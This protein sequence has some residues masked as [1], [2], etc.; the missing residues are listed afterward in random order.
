[1]KFRNNTVGAVL[2]ALPLALAGCGGGSSGGG[3][4]GGG[5]GGGGGDAP[6]P[7]AWMVTASADQH[8]TIMPPVRRVKDGDTATFSLVPGTGYA[9]QRVT[10]CNGKLE[11][12][13]YT[14]RPV[15]ANCAIK[16]A[17]APGYSVGGTVSGL[18]WGLG[19]ELGDRGRGSVTASANGAFTLPDAVAT[20]AGYEVVVVTQPQG[21]HCEVGNGNGTIADAAVTHVTVTCRDAVRPLYPQNGAGW[22]D[23]VVNDGVDVWTAT[24]LACSGEEASGPSGCLHGGERRQLAVSGVASC[25]GL[26]ATDELDAFDWRCDESAGYVRFLAG[27]LKPQRPL[28]DLLDF[29]VAGWK[30]NQVTVRDGGTV[31]AQSA[32]TVWWS[33]PVRQDNDG[34]SATQA[35]AAGTVVLVSQNTAAVYELGADR[36]ALVVRPGAVLSAPGPGGS[37]V[38][39]D[40][41]RFLWVEGSINA[42]DKDFGI[43]ATAV[44]QSVFRHLHV[45]NA[46]S[47]ALYLNLANDNRIEQ[48][49]LANN[50]HSLYLGTSHR[51]VIQR[52]AAANSA[53]GVVLDHSDDN[54]VSAITAAN[55]VDAGLLLNYAH[56][57]MVTGAVLAN[58]RDVGLSLMYSANNLV[59]DVVVA[60][61]GTGV[62]LGIGSNGNVFGGL[63]KLGAN[64]V[65]CNVAAGLMDGLVDGTCANSGASNAELTTGISLA[66]SFVG[67][68]AVDDAANTSDVNGG[69]DWPVDPATFDWYGFGNEMRG[70]GRDGEAFASSGNQGR[71]TSAGGRVWDWSAAAADTVIRGALAYPDGDSIV[72]HGWS[73][74]SEAVFLRN[75][76]EVDGDRDGLCESGETCLYT[77][78][79]GAYQGHGAL[80]DPEVFVGGLISDVR[81]LGFHFN[82]R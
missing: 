57:N 29:D 56:H 8:G 35:I 27:S 77:H 47:R 74:D 6:T 24:D 31:V 39:A 42:L 40:A 70:W 4:D 66:G 49:M 79:L 23:Y 43:R 63:L 3:G 30:P 25:A 53:S 82:G 51:N 62:K 44:E 71:W 2:L 76:L 34:M 16:A 78:N 69:A 32:R 64:G 15:R 5:G 55:I 80:H 33:N 67:K 61:G 45:S 13:T 54:L 75:A 68:L 21:M 50:T 60:H 41:H 58:Q 17:F 72:T 11:G 28:A 7:S 20:G 18:A 36:L 59:G 9:V 22:N 10:G 73:D 46:G 48:A 52:L 26:A 37:V 65:S 38:S 1:M 81:V 12:H 14:T 19:V